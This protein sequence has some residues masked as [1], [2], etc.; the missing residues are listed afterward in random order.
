MKSKKLKGGNINVFSKKKD[1]KKVIKKI[2][3]KKNYFT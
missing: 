3:K 2:S 1:L